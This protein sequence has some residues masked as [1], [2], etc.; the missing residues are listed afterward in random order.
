MSNHEFI[1]PEETVNLLNQNDYYLVNLTLTYRGGAL[2]ITEMEVE[3]F[4]K[5][6]E[7]FETPPGE[8][9]SNVTEYHVN[10]HR[11]IG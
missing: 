9:I 4:I 7:V 3:S 11:I 10:I 5:I 8:I 1:I 2:K 6:H